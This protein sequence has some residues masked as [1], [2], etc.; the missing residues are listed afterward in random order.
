MLLSKGV[1]QHSNLKCVSEEIPGKRH[2]GDWSQNL[3][4]IFVEFANKWKSRIQPIILRTVANRRTIT[5]HPADW[6]CQV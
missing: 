6:Y 4:Y 5:Y 3:V 2:A 1:L